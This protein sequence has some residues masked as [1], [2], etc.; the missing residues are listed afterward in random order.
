MSH[1]R[2]NYILKDSSNANLQAINWFNISDLL[3]VEK[4]FWWEAHHPII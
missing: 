2:R 4:Y 1:V 3:D